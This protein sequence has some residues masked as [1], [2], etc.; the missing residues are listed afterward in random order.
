MFDS[1]LDTE[2]VFGQHARMHRTYV[3]RR[4]AAL[5][6]GLAVLGWGVP[7]AARTVAGDAAPSRPAGPTY[8][9]RPGDTLWAIALRV[10]PA[11]DPRA[12]VDRIVG[13]NGIDAGSLIP[14]Q[15]LVL[16]SA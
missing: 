4:L 16:P 15:A 1:S 11:E 2:R 7:A 3:R 10:A 14:G 13:A 5:A 6:L 12:V 8:V 9:V